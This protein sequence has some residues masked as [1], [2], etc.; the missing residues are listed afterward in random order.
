MGTAVDI[1]DNLQV[2]FLSVCMYVCMYTERL[3]RFHIDFCHHHLITEM[4]THL[5]AYYRAGQQEK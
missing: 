1:N 4:K 3:P 5:H 2:L